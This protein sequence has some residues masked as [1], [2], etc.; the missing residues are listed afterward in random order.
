MTTA[1][2]MIDIQK[3]MWMEPKPPHNDQEFLK[4]ATALLEKARAKGVP[5][6]HIRHDGGEGD[7][8]HE[9]LE[10]FEIRPEVAPKGSE[11]IVTK[12]H[13]SSFKDTGLDAEL[14]KLGVD[15]LVI[16][17]MQTDFCVDTACRVAHSL[18]Y[19]V[20]LAEDAHT[21][22][23]NATMS[24]ADTIAYH[25]GLLKDRFARFQPVAK[26]EFK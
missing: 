21:T 13:C 11:K 18:G 9:G 25:S 10:G 12:Y 19:D 15:K 3:A 5:V 22:L 14:R 4:N 26:I 24:A 6:I 2:L 20:T 1:L 7:A 23:D 16:A 17:G 8:F